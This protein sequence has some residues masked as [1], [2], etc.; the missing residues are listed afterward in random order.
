MNK[1]ILPI[2]IVA[3]L[4]FGIAHGYAASSNEESKQKIITAI[5]KAVEGNW[6]NIDVFSISKYH[7]DNT[8]VVINHTQPVDNQTEPEP[9]PPGWF[10]I[11][12]VCST[13]DNP[14]KPSENKTT[15]IMAGDISG[16]TIV[17]A[18][19]N[20]KA[21][22]FVGLG[23]LTYKSTL[24]NFKND[25][26]NIAKIVKC[27]IGN[28]DSKEDGSAAIYEEAK[29]YCG[30]YWAFKVANGKAV[31]V[32]FNSNA[33]ATTLNAIKDNITS[34][35]HDNDY[36]KGVRSVIFTSHKPCQDTPPNSHHGLET[37]LKTFCD[38]VKTQVPEGVIAYFINGHNHVYSENL[39]RNIFQVGTG[40]RSH[41]SC[42]T[43]FIWPYC[44]NQDYGY[45]KMVIDGGDKGGA[46]E[47][48]F[49]GVN[50]GKIH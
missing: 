48:H 16:S 6:S 43:D 47:T 24:T 10:L 7:N 46:I 19:A 33:D 3:V 41:Y 38:S 11:D 18:V 34:L 9:C 21:D 37:E 8:E 14:P 28:H 23:D 17:S 35:L 1:L 13:D 50:G 27:L 36:M 4:V 25:F 29:Q 44:N 5:N 20:E 40:G 12:G 15:I 49:Y 42:G 22:I 26:G 32:G 2:L 31:L 39:D 30:E 45:L